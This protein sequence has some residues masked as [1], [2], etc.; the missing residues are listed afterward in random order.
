MKTIHQALTRHAGELLV[1]F[2]LAPS[3][4]CAEE[5]VVVRGDGQAEQRRTGTIIEYTGEQLLLRH[6]GGR[7]ERIPSRQ[8]VEVRGDW[9]ASHRAANAAFDAHRYDE[10]AT[11]YR[12]ALQEERRRWVQRRVL[13]QLT[14]CYRYLD[15]TERAVRLFLTL[16]RDDP[17]TLDFSAIPLSWIASQPPADLDR[18]AAIWLADDEA[19]A[20]LIGASWL[21]TG[22]QRGSAQRM[23]QQLAGDPDAR[24]AFLAQAQL[25]RTQAATASEQDIRSWRQLAEKMPPSIRSGPSFILGQA[26]SQR[27]QHAEAALA[28]LRPVVLD[29]SARDLI[30]HSLLAAGQELERMEQAAEAAGVYRELLADYADSSLA[31][32]AK[33]RLSQMEGMP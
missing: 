18:H 20:R 19:V 23:L 26:W 10:A 16:Y 12:Q 4:L 29:P 17:T 13:A 8:I 14:W 9:S 30:P 2:A 15:Q 27:G 1:L 6:D 32:Q 11:N 24:I 28:F 33:Q 21:L 22:S 7:E 25:W 5:T 31:A 3:G